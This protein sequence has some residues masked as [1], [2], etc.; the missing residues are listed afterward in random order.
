LS[1]FSIWEIRDLNRENCGGAASYLHEVIDLIRKPDPITRDTASFPTTF[2]MAVTEVSILKSIKEFE[3][4]GQGSLGRLLH[5]RNAQGK[6]WWCGGEFGV[7]N[8]YVTILDKIRP[9][10]SLN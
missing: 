4:S 2:T 8:K 3:R 7:N 9:F 5:E 1:T 10:V 6:M